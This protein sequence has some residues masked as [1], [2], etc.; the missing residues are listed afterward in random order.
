MGVPWSTFF[1]HLL[2]HCPLLGSPQPRVICFQTH[3]ER[4]AFEC[5]GMP[6]ESFALF[7]NE[8]NK[9]EH[10]RNS[11]QDISVSSVKRPCLRLLIANLIGLDGCGFESQRVNILTEV[12]FV[13]VCLLFLP[14]GEEEKTTKGKEHNKNES[15]LFFDSTQ[16]SL[17]TDWQGACLKKDYKKKKKKH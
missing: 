12:K 10:I 1:L 11:P 6:P 14:H 7:G 16:W 9:R 5:L 4:E 2:N 15:F 13:E 17:I 8:P 3:N